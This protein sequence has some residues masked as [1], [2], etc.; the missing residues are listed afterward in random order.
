MFPSVLTTFL[1][2]FS[3]IFASRSAKLLGGPVANLGR[4]IVA[5]CA[6]A[7]WAHGFGTGLR[8]PALPWLLAGG[9]IGFG[10]GDIALFGA[11][12]RIGPRLSILLTQCLA[13]PL[14]ALVEWRWLGSALTVREVLCAAWILTGVAL[15]LAPDHGWEGK[16]ST[17]WVGVLCG[18]GSA[19]GQGLGAVFTRKAYLVSDAAGF[20]IDGGS[21]AYQRIVGGVL[22]TWI[23]FFIMRRFQPEAHRVPEGTDW[24]AAAPVVV[25]NALS[26]PAFGVACFQWALKEAKTG[27]VLP[28]V[29]TSPLVT[30]FLAWFIDGSRPARR[31]IVG[32]VIAVLGAVAL[33]R[34]RNS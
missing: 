16:R 5:T 30:M 20:V 34:A 13:A 12:T 4:L 11:L 32:G 23:T 21:V 19:L 15:A 25:G 22:I 29:A 2:S 28:I 17:F 1:F 27:V 9:V 18:I 8:G 31:G 14:A 7:I 10:F 24:R 6:L 3:V 33:S 26:G